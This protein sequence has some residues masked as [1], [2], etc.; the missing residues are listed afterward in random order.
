MRI[1]SGEYDGHTHAETERSVAAHRDAALNARTESDRL[2]SLA[3]LSIAHYANG[4]PSQ[5]AR[6]SLARAKQLSRSLRTYDWVEANYNAAEFFKVAG[7]HHESLD[8]LRVL[9]DFLQN[10]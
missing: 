6:I 8:R 7:E 10:E 9:I 2:S 4:Q 3:H 1:T 5:A